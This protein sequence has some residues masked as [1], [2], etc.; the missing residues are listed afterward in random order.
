MVNVSENCYKCSPILLI[1]VYTS[2]EADATR[3]AADMNDLN[4]SEK[5]SKCSIF[6]SL[7]DR[8]FER[9]QKGDAEGTGM[10][11]CAASLRTDAH[12][13]RTA[14]QSASACSSVRSTSGKRDDVRGK[15][16][17]RASNALSAGGF[18]YV[19]SAAL[20]AVTRC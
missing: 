16:A 5:C 11:R 3:N 17:I 13:D 8:T 7:M 1:S 19:F 4:V 2:P 20:N 12:N 18:P 9:N 14:A 10:R 15:S 6:I